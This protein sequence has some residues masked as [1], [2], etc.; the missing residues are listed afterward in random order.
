[1]SDA[2]K[3]AAAKKAITDNITHDKMR[4]GIGSGSTMLYLMKSITDLLIQNP[5]YNTLYVIPTSIQ[6]KHL[7]ILESR[8]VIRA[9]NGVSQLIVTDLDSYPILDVAFDGADESM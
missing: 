9:T 8:K 2:G 7:L 4:I 3:K 6:T 1:M 5:K